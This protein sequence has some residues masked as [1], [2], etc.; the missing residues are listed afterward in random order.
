MDYFYN[1]IKEM[2]E[3]KKVDIYVDMDG[4]VADYD[5]LNFESVKTSPDAYLNKRPITTVI[6]IIRNLSKLD[7]VTIY[8]LS[9]AKQENQINGKLVWLSENMNFIPKSQINIIPRDTNG[10]TK[11]SILKKEFLKSNYEKDNISL[12]IDDSHDV[13]KEVKNLDIGIIPVHIST[14][15]D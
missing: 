13:L 10:W 7:N 14:V 6:N 4:V 2:A 5:L 8:I 3:N 15:I 1:K 11:A 12:M 9:V